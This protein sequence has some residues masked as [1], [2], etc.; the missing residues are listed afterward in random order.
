MRMRKSKETGSR[1][2]DGGVLKRREGGIAKG[3]RKGTR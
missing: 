3:E 1:W 2:K